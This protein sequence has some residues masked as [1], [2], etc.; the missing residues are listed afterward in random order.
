MDFK[1]GDKIKFLD[2]VGEGV[3]KEIL[4]D[5]EV[6]I[7]DQDGFD[8]KV[9]V[10]SILKSVSASEERMLYDKAM[11]S[12]TQIFD[13]DVNRE[14]LEAAQDK[15]HDQYQEKIPF[16]DPEVMEVDLHIHEL[17]D[18]T[19]GMQNGDMLDHQIRHFERMMKIAERKKFTK[20][21]FI[22]GVGEGVLRA[23]IR[24]LIE[25]FYP[26]CSFRDGNYREYG[27]GATQIHIRYN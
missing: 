17:I 23:E 13:K 10:S 6:L 22:H 8:Y 21:V 4:G 26:N 20:V 18:N 24:R 3:V 12:D 11:P 16:K 15:F 5:S 9:H 7:E 2:Q 14:K 27:I 19:S 1:V 25:Q